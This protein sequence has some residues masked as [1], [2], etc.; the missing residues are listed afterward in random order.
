MD[1]SWR[2][3]RGEPKQQDGGPCK[4]P[5]LG[6]ASIY[7]LSRSVSFSQYRRCAHEP[8][9][10][11]GLPA[12]TNRQQPSPCRMTIAWS[13]G[14]RQWETGREGIIQSQFEY[15]VIELDRTW[16]MLHTIHTLFVYLV[17]HVH[18]LDHLVVCLDHLEELTQDQLNGTMGPNG[19]FFAAQKRLSQCRS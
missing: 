1:R 5:N 8:S 17:D 11:V 4:A 7:S 3:V 14:R 15:Q 18:P 2:S 6:M 9:F 10:G 13:F 16:M 19:V 12:D